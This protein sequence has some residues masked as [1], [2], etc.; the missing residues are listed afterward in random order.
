MSG[1]LSFLDINGQEVANSYRTL[2][3]LRGGL[4][5]VK[6]E[7][8]SLGCAILS[9]EVGGVA[10]FVSPSA[11]PAPWY[12]AA[13]PESAQ[14]LGFLITD[15]DFKTLKVSRAIAQRLGGIS[16]G[17]IN[18]EQIEA[19]GV[20]VKGLL[21]AST[22]PG[23][24]YGRGWLY[25]KL[26][27]DCK[28]CTLSSIRVRD[29]CPPNDGSNDTRGEWIVY[30]AA[31]VEG[32]NR[33]DPGGWNCCDY[34]GI[35]FT[36]AGQSPYL[37][38]RAAVQATTPIGTT[39]GFIPP[40]PA[41]LD[42]FTR[43]NTGPPPSAS[44]TNTGLG[45]FTGSGLKVVSNAAVNNDTIASMARWNAA[46]FAADQIVY[47]TIPNIVRL[48]GN[49]VGLVGA[50]SSPGTG[51]ADGVVARV[52]LGGATGATH[53]TNQIIHYSANGATV[54]TI[55]DDTALR[56]A[57]TT[58]D[59]AAGDVMA[60]VLRASRAELWRK[61]AGVWTLVVGG[62]DSATRSTGAAGAIIYS[63]TAQGQTLDDFGAAALTN[64][65]YPF[66]A[67][68][69]SVPAAPAGISSPVITISSGG[70]SAGQPLQNLRVQ[71]KTTCSI[72]DDFAANDLASAWFDPGGVIATDWQIA[73]GKLNPKVT[74]PISLLR[75]FTGSDPGVGAGFSKNGGRVQADVTLGGTITSGEWTVGFK[76]AG[77]ASLRAASNLFTLADAAT[78]GAVMASTAFTPVLG[79]SY[80][81]VMEATRLTAT[82]TRVR[83]WLVDP[84][85]NTMLTSPLTITSTLPAPAQYIPSI[86]TRAGIT[87][88]AWDSFAYTDYG[89]ESCFFDIDAPFGV[90][91]LDASRRVASFTPPSTGVSVD[92]GQY[93]TTPS[94]TPMCWPDVCA[95]A[96]G[97]IQVFSDL[98]EYPSATVSVALQT[99]QRG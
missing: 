96:A 24:E 79:T 9:R 38:K 47:A 52:L 17:I 85:T 89:D 1:E 53:D 31:L 64:P 58:N 72:T 18:F 80:R 95:P 46:T 55:A 92:G 13:F 78:G 36:I 20:H 70:A 22:C 25:S 28:G 97:C 50:L 15:L 33:D 5:A 14:F 73:A 6:W 12:S 67:M 71:A 81:I 30:D 75:S 66:D 74:T 10:P 49:G 45:T 43:A 21:M 48:A 90:F 26:G 62:Y 99:R 8:G 93:M 69:V 61:R 82:T 3:Y 39:G 37:Y 42:N 27:S 41:V 77:W 63:P 60:L 34:D 35:D 57:G 76:G 54:L 7:V 88:D 65:Y 84:A 51:S 23:L 40:I 32:I 16:G 68:N 94:G 87:T 44:W 98:L 59:W 56:N 4:G 11:D 83:A 29:S 91:V 2:S 19:R 86:G